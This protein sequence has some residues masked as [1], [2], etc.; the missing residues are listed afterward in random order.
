MEKGSAISYWQKGIFCVRL[1]R[2]PFNRKT[3]PIA[4]GIDPGSKREGYTIATRKAV[5]L[6]IT[7]NT[8]DWVK[9]HID[10]R[11][12]LRRTRRTRKTPYRSCRENRATLRKDR[13]PPSTKAR[14]N[15]KLR[16]VKFLLK[17]IPITIINV[18]DIAA[19]TKKGQAKWNL[20][21]SP[22]EVGKVWFYQEIEN[23]GVQ[24]LKTQ[25]HQTQEK[26][27][28]RGFQKSYSK[29]NYSWNAHNVDSHVLAEIAMETEILPYYGLWK[30]EFLEFHRRQLHVQNP[31][32]N[33]V[34]KQYGTTISIGMSRGSVVRYKNKFYYL[35][36]S[37]KGKVSIH[38]IITGK[39]VKQSVKKRDI[40]VLY[41]Q[42]RRVQFLPRL[43]SWVFLNHFHDLKNKDH[44]YV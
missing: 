39:R 41:T 3:Q 18:E 37:S 36:G 34:R 10:T 27:D 30:V 17:I 42:N 44:M 29:L 26:R 32:K 43:K 40:D 31:I 23:L 9:D 16:M 19:A 20:S 14:W 11:R 21:F 5:V 2:E 12:Q 35:G 15:A 7:T 1:T 8:T 6:N 4:L 22:L 38:S 25:G 13:V 33:N 28:Q 24:L